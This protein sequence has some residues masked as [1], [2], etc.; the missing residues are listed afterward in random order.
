MIV[1]VHQA[2]AFLHEGSEMDFTI[3]L[4]PLPMRWRAR[5][6]DV[7]PRGFT[8]CQLL[9]PFLEWRHRHTFVPL[10]E[11]ETEVVDEVHA[12]LRPHMFWGPVGLAMWL[13]LPALFIYRAWKTRRL[14]EDA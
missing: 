4:G 13:G 7:G 9:G 11:A 12:A 5:M 3:W 6:E 10:S 8:D 14:L 2:P 1:R